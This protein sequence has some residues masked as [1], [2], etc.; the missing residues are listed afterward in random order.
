MKTDVHTNTS[1]NTDNAVK[2]CNTQRKDPIRMLLE[3]QEPKQNVCA[4]FTPLSAPTAM[5]EPSRPAGSS[6]GSQTGRSRGFYSDTS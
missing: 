5:V 1:A 3:I 6:V 2:N 4:C